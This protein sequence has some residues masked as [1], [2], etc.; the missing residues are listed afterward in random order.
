MRY[1]ITQ[2]AHVEVWT[3]AGPAIADVPAGEV[4]AADIDAAVL[5]TLIR[6]GLATPVD[7]TPEVVEETPKAPKSKK[8]KADV[9]VQ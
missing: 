8:E 2:D 9:T 3:N 4:D 1:A 6:S 5:D 7:E